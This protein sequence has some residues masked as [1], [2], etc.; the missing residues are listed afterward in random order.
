MNRSPAPTQLAAGPSLRPLMLGPG[1]L[2][3]LGMNGS[4]PFC[5]QQEVDPSLGNLHRLWR[6]REHFAPD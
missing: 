6:T 3:L 5:A 1:L 4:L 2:L